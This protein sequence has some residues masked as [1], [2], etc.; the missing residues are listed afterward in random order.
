MRSSLYSPLPA[1]WPGLW[2][3]CKDQLDNLV[4]SILR[5]TDNSIVFRAFQGIGASGL[6]C[7]V[8]IAILRLISIEKA[9]FYSGIISSVFAM[10]SLLGLILGGVIVDHT[11][12]RWIFSIMCVICLR[13]LKAFLLIINVQYSAVGDYHSHSLFCHASIGRVQVQPRNPRTT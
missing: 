13:E 11:T 3:S 4:K 6:Y 10:S 12:W 9:G 5:L 7:L 1:V 2:T 8:F